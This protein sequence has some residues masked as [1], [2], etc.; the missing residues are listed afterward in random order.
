MK[1]PR[2]AKV[3]RGQLDVAPVVG[4]FFLLLIFLLLQN[5]ITFV[6]GVPVRLPE[7]ANLSGFRGPAL[8]VIVDRGGQMFFDNQQLAPAEMRNQIRAAVKRS[9][10]PLTLVVQADRDVTSGTLM[11]LILMA[12]ESGISEVFHVVKPAP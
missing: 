5:Y 10:L 8:T 3:F 2:N 11:E 4:V 7:G 12:R 6:P 9:E 1:L